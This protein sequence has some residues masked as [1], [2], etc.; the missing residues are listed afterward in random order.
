MNIKDFKKLCDVVYRRVGISIDERK[1]DSLSKK[2]EKLMEQ[3]GYEDFRS[4]FHALRFKNES[5]MQDII[6]LVTVN[7]TY[8]FRENYQFEALV[9]NI[10]P[11]ID[12][13]LPSNE[14]IRI[15]CSPTS[16]G[17]E[18]YSIA[19]HLLDEGNLV[20]KRD[21]EIIGM[22]IDS[23]VIAR[24][25]R[26]IYSKRSV[27]FLPPRLLNKYF[28]KIDENYYEIDKF[29]RDA[30]TFK[31]VNVMDKFAMK[32]LGKFNVIFCR[33][34]LIYFDDK[35][36]KEVAMTF[37]DMLKPHGY[38]FLGHAESMNRI[39]SVYKTV[40]VNNTIIYQKP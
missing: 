5:L 31:V 7:E 30:I 3:K 11:E 23:N 29:L 34:M 4:F 40:K 8:F 18:A 39:V 10:L 6:N 22:D 1:Y 20:E 14:V 9:Q 16:T 24:A 17:E 12:K 33:N 15:L 27:Q 32:R 21:F 13:E 2:I 25:N 38:V 36:R 35:S 26:G 28:K 37:Y 19:L